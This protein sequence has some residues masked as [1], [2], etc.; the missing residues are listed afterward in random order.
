MLGTRS[1]G[2][3]AHGLAYRR[4]LLSVATR[5]NFADPSRAYLLYD[6]VRSAAVHGEEPPPVPEDMQRAFAWDVRWALGEYLNL[7]EREGFETRRAL[8]AYLR[9][10]PDRKRLADWLI[11][12]DEPMWGKFFTTEEQS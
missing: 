9:E 12:T 4:A 6:E 10:H 2:L 1:E 11:E 3:K 5:E 8:L 7:A